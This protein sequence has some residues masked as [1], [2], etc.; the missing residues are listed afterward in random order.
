MAL[1]NF[2]LYE[3]FSG[4]YRGRF[5]RDFVNFP[6][7]VVQTIHGRNKNANRRRLKN[8]LFGSV[9]PTIWFLL[10][11]ISYSYSHFRFEAGL[12]NYT[13]LLIRTHP[14]PL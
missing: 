4:A 13:R 10:F 3:L 11:S 2:Q 6:L 5:E 14:S 7:S 9:G 1:E 8:R 12:V